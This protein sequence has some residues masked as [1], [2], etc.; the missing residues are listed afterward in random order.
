MTKKNMIQ[1]IQN[2]EARM[3][4]QYM[5]AKQHHGEDSSFVRGCRSRW[6][7]VYELMEALGISQDC[8]HPDNRAAMEIRFAL[9]DAV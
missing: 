3:Y 7:G 9:P 2:Q 4:L 5:L 6:C 1:E 8:K